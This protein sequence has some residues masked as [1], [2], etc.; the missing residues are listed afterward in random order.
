MGI[1]AGPNLLVEP[2]PIPPAIDIE[3][4]TNGNQA[5]EA[6]DSD[7]PRIAQGMSVNWTYEV[8]NTGESAI[9]ESE[10]VVFD[11]QPGVS[12]VMDVGSDEGDDMILSPGESWT[13]TASAQALDLE[14]PPEGITVVPGCNDNRNTYQNTGRA[15]VVGTEVFDE[16]LSHYC[17]PMIIDT[18]NDGILDDQYNCILIPNADQRDTDG[19]DYGNVCDGDLNN[20]GGTNTLDLNLY[21]LAHRSAIGD[22]NYNVHADFNWDGVINT[23]DL[24]IYKGLHRKPPGPSCC[25]P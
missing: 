4:L 18:D 7:V 9:S 14:N 15:E 23:L 10:I 12:P 24:N 22:A 2:V 6:N 1:Y 20:D 3:K 5:D 25:A 17:N 19:D 21:K 13:Y 16:D 8:S 11:D